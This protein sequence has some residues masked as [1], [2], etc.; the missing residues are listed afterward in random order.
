MTAIDFPAMI[1]AVLLAIVLVVA[2]KSI[3]SIFQARAQRS[4]DRQYRT[5][6]ETVVAAQT[7][8]QATLTAIRADLSKIASSLAAVE[9]LLK[10]VE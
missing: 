6:T 1:Y 5:L 3:A 4:N 10:Q 2:V 7:E 9:M 8:Y